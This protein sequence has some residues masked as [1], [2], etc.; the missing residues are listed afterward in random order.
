MSAGDLQQIGV[1]D[2]PHR[3]PRGRYATFAYMVIVPDGTSIIA[4]DDARTARWWPLDGLPKQLA[5]D[6]ADIISATVTP[7][8]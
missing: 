5:F 2:Q 6:H 7:N 4:G 3:D 1:W 8:S